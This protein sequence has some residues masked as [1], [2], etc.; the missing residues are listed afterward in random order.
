MKRFTLLLLIVFFA[1]PAM[2]KP[3]LKLGLI[4][5]MTGIAAED[6]TAIVQ[7]V[8]LAVEDV[9]AEGKIEIE[10][11][12]EDD[13]TTPK[14]T[15]S[16]FKK[17]SSENVD[18][19][20]GATWDFTSNSIL[21]LAGAEKMVLLNP[22]TLPEILNLK[23]TKGYGFATSMSL[24]A[25]AD[26][27][28]KYLIG[29]GYKTFAVLY[30]NNNWGESQRDEYSNRAKKTGMKSRA[31]ISSVKFDQNEWRDVIPR[32]KKLSPDLI[33]ALLNKNDLEIFLRRMREAELGGQVYTS[34]ALLDALAEAEDP[35][36]YENA[37]AP[38][39]LERL[40]EQTDFIK[41]FE[42]RFSERPRLYADNAYDT[43]MLLAKAFAATESKDTLVETLKKTSY[44][45]LA[46]EYKYSEPLTFP[47]G[48][49]SLVCIENG[50][51]VVK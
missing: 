47:T 35:A 2:A 27:F 34:K 31:E 16:A 49:T 4:Q 23:Q 48:E 28:S 24:R 8:Q 41:H 36:I 38:Y 5:S 29:K 19:I 3:K 40:A 9:N 21:G 33:I 11:L 46:G 43:V 15:V 18:A 20:I 13:Q 42:A 6:G 30:A 12:T 25:E 22:C 17:L 14:E 7:G 39:P 50:K 32:L 51:P 44:K 45:G 1:N 10:L 26:K 37:C